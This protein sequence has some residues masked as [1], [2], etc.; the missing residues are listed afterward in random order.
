MKSRAQKEALC[1]EL[2]EKFGKA[3]VAIFTHFSGIP[4][5]DL[6][7]LRREIRNAGG[8][9]RVVKNSVARRAAQ[10]TDIALAS[11]A[12]EGP[13]AV[14]LG[15]GDPILPAKVLSAFVKKTEK[16]R[17]RGGVVEGRACEAAQI[18]SI[19][20]LPSREVLLGRLVSRLNAPPTQL[21]QSLQAIIAS[22]ARG[23]SAV[24]GAR[25]STTNET[26]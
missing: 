24:A 11:S 25:A 15:Y 5:E 16:L 21:A 13:V 20:S 14:T 9:F 2:H 18:V 4:V 3:T 8:E 7:V 6:R 23:L 1:G 10:G 22:F 12:F 19:A 17:I 26:V